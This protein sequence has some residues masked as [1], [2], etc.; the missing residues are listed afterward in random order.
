MQHGIIYLKILFKYHLIFLLH[1][2][3]KKNYGE[4]T[5]QPKRDSYMPRKAMAHIQVWWFKFP[6]KKGT[7]KNSKLIFGRGVSARNRSL[8][9]SQIL[10]IYLILLHDFV[11]FERFPSLFEFLSILFIFQ[12][13]QTRGTSYFSENPDY[14]M[15]AKQLGFVMKPTWGP[16]FR[17]NGHDCDGIRRLVNG[18]W[19]ILDTTPPCLPSFPKFLKSKQI[20]RSLWTL[21]PSLYFGRPPLSSV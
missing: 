21:L 4:I 14:T 8:E 3:R 6:K 5:F 19:L 7:S 11:Q 16:Y 9:L 18:M 2:L 17:H 12:H 15:Y 13:L 1:I 10:N 20:L